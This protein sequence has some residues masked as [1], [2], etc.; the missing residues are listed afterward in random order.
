[1]LGNDPWYW[2]SR[3]KKKLQ[4]IKNLLFADN[5]VFFKPVHLNNS[6]IEITATSDSDL[7]R[8][9]SHHASRGGQNSDWFTDAYLI[10]AQLFQ[11]NKEKKNDL[12]E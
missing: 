7:M 9:P 4:D 3:Q 10:P 11:T 12:I 6:K 1:M 2:I 5:R 8:Q